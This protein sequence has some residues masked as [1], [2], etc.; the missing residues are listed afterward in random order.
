MTRRVEISKRLVLINST[1][2]LVNM[3]LNMSVLIWLQQYLLR[4][5]TA[6]EY[7]LLPVLYSV[8]MFAPLVTI[9]L[10][11]GLGR[12]VVEAHAREDDE[13]VTMIVST[14]FP[15]LS[16][17]GLLFLFGGSI[18]AW[19]INTILKIA[20]DR[21]WDARIMMAILMFSA[22]VRLPLAPFSVGLY[23]RQK[24]VL[25]NLIGVG[26]EI[27][28]LALLFF[29]LLAVS[30]RILWVVTA[31]VL[32][33]MLNLAITTIVSCRLLPTLRFRR[34]SINWGIARELTSFGGLDFISS[35]ANTIRT[36]AD[37]IILNRFATAFDV[38]CFALGSMPARQVERVFLTL[39]GPLSPALTAMHAANDKAALANVYVRGGRLALWASLLFAIPGIIYSKEIITLYVGAQ[40]LPAAIV[41]ML[42]LIMFPLAYGNTMLPQIASAKAD[43]RPFTIRTVAMN[44]AN[45]AL[46]LYLVGVLRLGAIGSA[47]GTMIAMSFVY[48]LFMWPLGR[49]MTDVSIGRWCRETVF[50]GM[51]PGSA[52]TILW[53]P[54]KQML[55][56]DTWL[57]L[58]LCVAGGC[59]AYFGILLSVAL[60]PS[61][62][63]DLGRLASR[64]PQ[65]VF[66]HRRTSEASTRADG[67]ESSDQT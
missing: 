50:P 64:F 20:P 60:R 13:R 28:R 34:E 35:V 29:F 43:L 55:H 1:S 33:E 37:P 14:M 36:S 44:T 30:T 4:H 12:Y 40:Y 58:G 42:L 51:L 45:L 25:Q 54:L 53:I 61:D 26:T 2:S 5:I 27:F 11:G 8:M 3:L 59:I 62:R 39:R 7:S 56:P 52:G 21:V 18:L 38:T 6:E 65:R 24:F 19:H 10:A 48:P 15:I 67:R 9:I 41:M 32:A 23:A 49:R 22:A 57:K 63:E 31:A 17:A 47:L 66:S 46:T 16:A